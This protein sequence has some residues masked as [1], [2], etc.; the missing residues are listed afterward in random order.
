MRRQWKQL[1]DKL[2]LFLPNQPIPDVTVKGRRMHPIKFKTMRTL[3][4]KFK[5]KNSR[6][7]SFQYKPKLKDM[8][9]NHSL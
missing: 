6:Y 2:V 8:L 1:Q 5:L 4:T 3:R 7:Q 9:S